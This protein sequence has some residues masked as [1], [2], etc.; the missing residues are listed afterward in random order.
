[1]LRCNLLP[2]VATLALGLLVACKG[3]DKASAPGKDGTVAEGTVFGGSGAADSLFFSIERTPCFGFCPA[4]RIHLYRSGL[5][6]W[7]GVS[8]VERMEPHRAK[9]TQADMQRLLDEAGRIG[10][11]GMKESYDGPVTDLPSTIIRVV[12]GD[13]DHTVHARYRV[14]PELKEYGALADTL[15]LPLSWVPVPSGH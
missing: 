2:M 1:M 12:S 3:R 7:E 5:A 8:Q 14:P 11:F 4:Y 15:L 10:F 13:R 9:A 6:T